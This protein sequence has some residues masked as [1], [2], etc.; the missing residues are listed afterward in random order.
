[1]RGRT[2]SLWL[3]AVVAGSLAAT[4]PTHVAAD[5][6]PVPTDLACVHV[7][8][9]VST[10]CPGPPPTQSGGGS[11]SHTAVASTTAAR[12]N[13][14]TTPAL[15]RALVAEVNRI[16]RAHGLR[17]LAYSAKLASAGT[18]HAHALA[19]AGQFTHVWPTTGRLFGSWIREF[20]P[21]RGFR[22]WGAGENLL[23]AAPSF[24]PPSAVQQWLDSPTHRRL[25]LS[26]MWREIGIGVVTAAAAP[27][28]YGERDV[29]IAAAEFGVRR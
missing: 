6:G 1:M 2:R 17:R 8:P 19:A 10:S 29:Q 24:S 7:S 23:W 14:S 20:Y 12:F 28:A 11:A 27:G 21:S 3:S 25:M 16:R 13:A 26:R 15:A 22:S 5:V 9:A 18:A 4:I